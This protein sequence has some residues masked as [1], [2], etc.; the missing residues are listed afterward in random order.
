MIL[1]RLVA[2]LGLITCLL[3][4]PA[5]APAAMAAAAAPAAAAPQAAPAPVSADELQRLVDTLQNEKQRDQLVTQLQAL[6]AAQRGIEAAQ[7]PATPAGWLNTLS[8]NVD[9]IS[10]E[11]LATAAVVL[12][13]PSLIDWLQGQASD[14]H[15]RARWLAI[16]LRLGIILGVA[17]IGEWFVRLLLRR[18]RARLAARSS[19]AR[20]AELVLMLALF[21]VDALPVIAFAVIAYAVLPLVQPRSWATSVQIAGVVIQASLTARLILAA[22][23]V[24]LLSIPATAL[25]PLGE[26]TRNYLY[27]WVRRF[28]NWSVYGLAV[29]AVTW[30]FGVPGAIYV[31]LLRGTML[32]LGILSVIFVLQNRVAVADMLRGKNGNGAGMLTGGHGWRL[33]RHRLADT[34]H[35]LAILYIAG[36]F[37]SY[38]LR[39]Q[40]GF[41]YVF[42]AT[43]LSLVVILAAGIIVRAVRQLSQRGF[44]IGDDLKRR[45]PT[46]EHRA[47]RYVPILTIVASV[48]VYVFAALALLQ[49][50]GIDTFSWFSTDTGRRISGG[51]VSIV[52]VLL[53]ALLIW[54]IFGA[55]IERYLNGVGVDGHR[56]ARSAR[57]RTLLPLLRTTV[58]II[59]LT[60][61]GLI[62]LSELGLNIAPLLAGAGIAGIAVGFGSQALVKDVITGLFIL[63]EDTLAV[64]EMVDVGNNHAGIVEA[65]SVRTIRLRDLSGTL[66]TVPFSDV[67]TVRNLTRDYSYFVADVGVVYREDPDRVIAVLREVGDD[68]RRDP[69]WAPSIVEPLEIFGVERFSDT[70]MVVRARLKTV[71]MRQFAIGREFNRRMKKAFDANGIEMPAGNQTRYLDPPKAS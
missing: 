64:G 14:S 52:T 4:A 55:A 42:R 15:A 20:L 65:I 53:A 7:P 30:W 40:A 31:L 28:T 61:V 54:E 45:F 67:S 9:A 10:A 8:A 62:V 71:P 12:D 26:E 46:L 24:A 29:A 21:V 17:I 27:I 60:T 11:I 18:P 66:H 47:N 6:I 41:A 25:Y 37:G 57:T 48:I 36:T 69:D 19:D 5:L 56:V 3:L 58:L 49:A 70:A 16:G 39:I 43:I 22:A 63:L 13:A 2:R 59:L 68:L 34:W 32:V 1:R 50:W 23:N 33:L 44:A 35:V 51:V 38:V